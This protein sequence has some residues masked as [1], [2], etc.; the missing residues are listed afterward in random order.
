[1]VQE[2]CAGYDDMTKLRQPYSLSSH[3]SLARVSY[4]RT[5]KLQD[6]LGSHVGIRLPVDYK[7]AIL[8]QK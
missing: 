6:L 1:L 5:I 3:L 2:A 8:S 4:W 7:A